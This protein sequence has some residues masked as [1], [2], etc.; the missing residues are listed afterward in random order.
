MSYTDKVTI[1]IPIALVNIANKIAKG[2][3]PDEAGEKTFQVQYGDGTTNTHYVA[4]IPCKPVFSQTVQLVLNGTLQLSQVVQ[5][6]Y[7]KEE[8]TYT[9]DANGDLVET[10]TYSDRW[11]GLAPPTDA[12]C[13]QFM[14]DAVIRINTPLQSVLDELGLKP[15]K[16]KELL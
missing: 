2:L 13:S 1:V 14:T 15:I 12:E 6:G 9:E 5:Q 7:L 8:K 4:E 3:D 10:V 11:V 16:G